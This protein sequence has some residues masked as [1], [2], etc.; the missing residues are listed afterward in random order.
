MDT[1]VALPPVILVTAAVVAGAII[2]VILAHVLGFM[3]RV[4]LVFAMIA[5]IVV[6]I[7]PELVFGATPCGGLS[8]DPLPYFKPDPPPVY[9][10]VRPHP[11]AVECAI[12]DTA[13]IRAHDAPV[14]QL[15]ALE[16]RQLCDQAAEPQRCEAEVLELEM[17]STWPAVD[18]CLWIVR[19]EGKF[20]VLRN[21]TTGVTGTVRARPAWRA[22]Q[23][24][25]ACTEKRQRAQ[26]TSAER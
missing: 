18:P 25:G 5:G 21:P 26:R 20:A 1:V 12:D 7:A 14:I 10:P 24:T 19:V 9:G 17:E 6:A 11:V 13:C 2:G 16:G 15:A 3:L 23:Y 4:V 8:L 22:H